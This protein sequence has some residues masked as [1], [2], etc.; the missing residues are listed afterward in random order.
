MRIA[1]FN[2][3]IRPVLSNLENSKLLILARIIRIA[4][5]NSIGWTVQADKGYY[6]SP[7]FGVSIEKQG[8]LAHR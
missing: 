4:V 5:D 2:Y 1:F 8:R 3:L 6:L 7:R